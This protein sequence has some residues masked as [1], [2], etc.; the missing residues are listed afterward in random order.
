MRNRETKDDSWFSDLGENGW[1]YPLLSPNAREEWIVWVLVLEGDNEFNMLCTWGTC[2]ALY[3]ETAVYLLTEQM[4][5]T[6]INNSGLTKRSLPVGSWVSYLSSHYL[7]FTCKS[8]QILL[9]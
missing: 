7:F 9:F 5:F 8:Y 2:E 6:F 3:S 4:H 1:W